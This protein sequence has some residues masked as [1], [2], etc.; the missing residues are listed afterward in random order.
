MYSAS[1]FSDD[2]CRFWIYDDVT[3]C[4]RVLYINYYL[5]L[6]LTVFA[7]LFVL[8]NVWSHYYYY[9][10]LHLKKPSLV[11]EILCDG[12]DDDEDKPLIS[13]LNENRYTDGREPATGEQLME[14][15]FSIE[16]LKCVK[17]NGE[18]HGK[19]EFVKRGFVEKSRT[20]VEF[21]LVLAQFV[22]H[23]FVYIHY[24]KNYSEF[25][26]QSS[27]MGIVQWGFLLAIVSLRLININQSIHGINKY[28]GNIW[29]ISF[30]SYLFLFV[31]N[32][33]PFRSIYIGHIKNKLVKNYY[34]SQTYID[35]ILFL[36]LFF[37]PSGNKDPVIYKTDDE[38][39]PSPEPVSSIASFISW[40]WLDPFI[41]TAHKS[42]IENKDVWGLSLEDYS[43]FVVK[44]F[45]H[46]TKRFGKKRGFA[47]NL[48][49]FFTK[50]LALQGFW[51]C[52]E[53]IVSFIPTL[54]LKRILEYVEDRESAPA[55]LAWFYVFCMFFCR[56]FV[57]VCQGQALFFGRRVCIRM[58]A[59][60]ISEI[61][62]KALKR[63]ISVKSGKQSTDEI[64]PQKLNEQ[65]KIDGDEESSS[66][67][68]LG[69][70]INLMAVDAFKV[71]EICAYL[72]AFVEATV[73]AL[74][75]IVLLYHLLG[76]AAILGAVLIIV[77]MPFNFK[78]ATLLG[79]LQKEN[80]SVTDKRIQKLNE[81]FQAIR[82]IKFFSWEENFEKDIDDIR[83]TELKL[84][85]KRSLVW[86]MSSFVWYI[87]PTIVTSAAFWFYIYIQGE[88]LTTP[89]AFT[90][91]S[92]FSLLRTPLDQLSDMLSFVIQSKV[93]LDRVQEFLEEDDTQKYSQLNVAQD[94][95]KIAFENATVTWDK[96]RSDFKLRDLNIEFKLG[97]LNVI[98]GPT[99]SGK[100]SL[101]MALLGEMHLMSGKI[102][103]PSLDPRQQ[104]AV[105]AD[106]MTN[107]IAY[108][109]Q[110][111]WLLNDTVRNNILFNSPYNE[112][113][114]E[115]VVEACGLKRDFAILS[116]GDMTEIG[117]RGITLSGG[118]KQRISLARSL[119]S[120]ARHV[121][122]DDCLSAVDS[123]TAAWIYDNC[124]T[125]PLMEGRTCILVSHNTAL[126]LRNAELI[127]ILENGQVKDQGEPLTLLQNGLLGEDEL[128]KSSILSRHNSS[129]NL[130]SKSELSMKNLSKGKETVKPLRT[131]EE[132]AKQG[133]LVEE[134]TK[135]QGTVGI[136]VYKWYLRIFG[137]WK[138]LSVLVAA[139][140]IA[141]SISIGQTW[142]VRSWVSHNITSKLIGLAQ[143]I[144]VS[145]SAVFSRMGAFTSS[146]TFA[147]HD[148][149][150][151][152]SAKPHS[153]VYYLT[154][155]FLIGVIQSI[156]S[157][158]KT[159]LSFVAGINASRKI[160]KQLLKRVMHAKLRFF[161]A[162]PIGRI[163]NR[164]SKDMEAADQE[165]TPF[166]E[167]AFYSL[168][169]CVST[170]VLITFITPQFLSVAILVA[171][172]YYFV[173]YFYLTGSRE[174]KRL[175]SI[176]RSPI[177]Q[178]FSE[179]LVGVTTIRAFGDESR[180]MRENLQKIDE[181]NK[182]F[183]YLWVA[184][185]WL[186]FR[187]DLIGALVVFGSGIFILL[188]IDHMDSGKAGISLTYA[189][190]FTEGALWLVRLY[191]NVEMNMNSVERLKEYMEV[192]QEPYD[193]SVLIPAPEWPQHGRIE[194]NDV[195]LRYAP[196]LPKVIKNV[197]F[198]VDPKAKVGIVGRTGA[199]KSTIITALFR[200]LDPETGNIKIDN[201]DITSV[202]L[203]RLRRSI[204]I[205]PQ[206]PTLF[207][208]TV[209]SNLDPYCEYSDQQIFE[210]LK[211]VNL[212]TQE[213]LDRS[214]EGESSSISSENVNKFLNLYSEISEGG[215]N[216]S[217]GQRQLVCLAR[218]L[219][220]CPKVILLDEATASIDYASD[221]KIQQ[222]IRKEFSGSTILTIAHRL[223]S[224]ID[225]DKILV[226]DAG[227]VK[228]FDHPYSLLLNKNSIFYSMCEQSGEL[229][230]LIESA[231]EAFVEK[232]N[233]K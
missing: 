9:D 177:Y 140:V 196:N 16:K 218:S 60:I 67:A 183:F 205:I 66:S 121:L 77:M 226:M 179:T 54:L 131:D 79:K 80:L 195:S 117:E 187:I 36:L 56:V 116:A 98:I 145:A 15:H 118:Q 100:T 37:S 231:K 209:K 31:S 85:L 227:E 24:S 122:L 21:L 46:Y 95:K 84:L 182:P 200:F 62:T 133:K 3:K 22:F 55:N 53:S 71:S 155:Y 111:A 193:Q 74:V 166:I 106:G 138:M 163:M 44:K 129:V 191:S 39:I 198:T 65:E 32:L 68:N 109:S 83:E 171:I 48:L 10:K 128:V 75:A 52:I 5:P 51:A 216:I 69:A 35:L 151:S 149:E 58:K 175:E 64:D 157:A 6:F 86:A 112:T 222:T 82:I 130:K 7:T 154:I 176:S 207:T 76:I 184:N 99:G 33:L 173:G 162:T 217:Q 20:I 61:Y 70:I 142:W 190:T 201:I 26:V 14:N 212:V 11:D 139:F 50:Y 47:V 136:D 134:E 192:D 150:E 143:N 172:L 25:P 115:A 105:E 43:I 186:S 220:R 93:S 1:G 228:E 164:F 19:P 148:V 215:G 169:S 27:V 158:L 29:A 152:A 88:V 159:V 103:V 141:Q 127:V 125:G 170:V 2:H 4:G 38:I 107:S 208:G 17:I 104:L 40:S 13:N 81:A 188:N 108:C 204:T 137:G 181:N 224:V 49:F 219:L 147:H 41:W 30:V 28:P 221:A 102:I 144:T 214:T 132:R 174:L 160:F 101:L 119:Y 23:C 92:L 114:Y 185:R 165:L 180:F 194:V 59:I 45:K 230:N 206:D 63:K 78:L 146:F 210:A 213:E 8:Y 197:S 189:I 135:A 91:L 94:R 199:G 211:R 203:Q 73:M 178:H 229:E 124:I 57:A 156:L 232:L 123:H 113:R 161:D 153:T 110:A 42:T 233:A 126:T 167:G 97:K 223:R 18:P 72:H 120:N 225:Y 12:N 89:I 87:T 202:D 96:D 90:A 168:V 34:L